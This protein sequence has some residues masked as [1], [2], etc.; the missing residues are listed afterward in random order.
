MVKRCLK[1]KAPL[2]GFMYYTIGKLFG[3]KSSA[4]KAGYCN[5]CDKD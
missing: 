1:C 4:K 2:E 5:K 3:L